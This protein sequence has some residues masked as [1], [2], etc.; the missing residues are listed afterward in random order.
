MRRQ[1][2]T[3]PDHLEQVEVRPVVVHA[4]KLVD[5]EHPVAAEGSGIAITP[6]AQ[7]HAKQVGGVSWL[8]TESQREQEA[9]L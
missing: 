5:E 1:A 4:P 6:S 3:Y 7:R 8:R 2:A 9:A